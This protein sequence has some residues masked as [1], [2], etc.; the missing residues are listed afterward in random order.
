MDKKL[1]NLSSF[2]V[3]IAIVLG[4]IIISGAIFA[5]QNNNGSDVQG[6]QTINDPISSID[7]SS[8][9]QEGSFKYQ[10]GSTVNLS[11]NGKPVIR[12]FSTTTCPH[13][14]FIKETFDGLMSEY[15]DKGLIEAYHWELDTY[16]NTLTSEV[17]GTVPETEWAIYQTFNPNGSV[18]TFVFGE[19]YYRIGN[20]GKSDLDFEKEEFIR[21]IDLI[22]EEVEQ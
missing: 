14:T 2:M 9:I 21:I 22:L 10:E 17:E 3:P 18:P 4:G 20:S 16:D 12:L 15:V 7:E 6:E 5:S 19:K 11:E 13:C 1:Q 8:V